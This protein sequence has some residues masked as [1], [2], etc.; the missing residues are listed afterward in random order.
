MPI[1]QQ[2][3]EPTLFRRGKTFLK[4][5]IFATL[6]RFLR[7][8]NTITVSTY[9][10]TARLIM[11]REPFAFFISHGADQWA[12]TRLV[13]PICEI[14]T[15][16]IWIGTRADLRK[17]REVSQN[18]WVTVAFESRRQNANLVIYGHAEI[19]TDPALRKRFWLD[20][21]YMFFPKGYKAPDYVL[22]QVVPQ[23]LELMSFAQNIVVE[24]FGLAP[25]V[26]IKRDGM[27]CLE[28][29]Q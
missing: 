19:R 10:E 18:P 9:M 12:S 21:W 3:P 1:A 13:Q 5:Q 8:K 16:E 25:A 6:K 26:L 24:P 2:A 28:E 23:R 15:L 22:I 4:G 17:V 29:H 27:W 20:S 7:S 14:D 11:Q